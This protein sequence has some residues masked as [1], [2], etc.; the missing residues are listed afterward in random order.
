MP[1]LGGPGGSGPSHPPY[2]RRRRPGALHDPESH[3]HV[4]RVLSGG[5]PGGGR[6][7]VPTLETCFARRSRVPVVL[8][9]S[10]HRSRLRAWVRT[11]LTG[12]EGHRD[13]REPDGPRDSNG[14][15]FC[16]GSWAGVSLGGRFSEAMR[17]QVGQGVA[18]RQTHP[19]VRRSSRRRQRSPS[20]HPSQGERPQRVQPSRRAWRRGAR[21]T[22]SST[23]GCGRSRGSGGPGLGCGCPIRG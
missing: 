23:G 22:A 15:G 16:Q 9:D 12:W 18:W 8:E 2:R 21:I 11:L 14:V 7:G 6:G 4:P 13:L 19:E 17:R 20:G 3:A 10:R 5:I 1:I